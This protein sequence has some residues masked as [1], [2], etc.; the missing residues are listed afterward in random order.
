MQTADCRAFPEQALP[1]GSF[2]EI[3]IDLHIRSIIRVSSKAETPS[4]HGI[5]HGSSSLDERKE[6]SSS[7]VISSD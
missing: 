3:E 7:W 1:L 2:T 4:V 6:C 5:K